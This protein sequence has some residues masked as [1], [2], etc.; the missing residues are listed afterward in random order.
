MTLRFDICPA[1]DMSPA[2][3]AEIDARSAEVFAEAIA[4]DIRW[5]GG[6]TRLV[7]W[8]GDQWVSSLEIAARDIRVGDTSL[9]VGGLS[10]VMTPPE[11]RGKGYA[12]AGV[13]RAD[14]YICQE[15]GLPFALLVTSSELAERLYGPLGWKVV[16][17]SL[18]YH[19][20]G[21]ARLMDD[22]AVMVFS[23]TNQPWPAGVIDLCGPP[24]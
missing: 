7:V 20:D 10:G 21:E 11:F 15:L 12:A 3:V 16:A 5:G 14:E 8:D 13:K 6:D 19:Q 24:W 4:S 23:C 18:I 17:D 2:L 9:F 22:T 1:A